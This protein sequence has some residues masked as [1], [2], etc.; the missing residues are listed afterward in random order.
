MWD[1]IQTQGEVLNAWRQRSWDIIQT[2]G[3]VLY[4]MYVQNVG[5]NSNTRRGSECMETEFMDI[6]LHNLSEIYYLIFLVTTFHCR[7]C[8]FC[9]ISFKSKKELWKHGYRDHAIS[10]EF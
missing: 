10:Q 8:K 3:G 6:N 5:L 9:G 7:Y 4:K 1:L 2:K